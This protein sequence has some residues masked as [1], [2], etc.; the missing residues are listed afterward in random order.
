MEPVDQARDGYNL[1]YLPPTSQTIA[2]N[3]ANQT[4]V[5]ARF[6]SS[7]A[8]SRCKVTTFFRY[9]QIKCKK[10][11]KCH[12][13]FSLHTPSHSIILRIIHTSTSSNNFYRD[14]MKGGHIHLPTSS[15][16]SHLQAEASVV[17][18]PAC[19]AGLTSLISH[20]HARPRIIYNVSFSFAL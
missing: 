11:F 16:L 13:F 18:C 2:P 20:S 7:Y 3:K 4:N 10:R 8:F 1:P 6:S 19:Y 15:H 9:T 17:M 12:S 14:L 5:L